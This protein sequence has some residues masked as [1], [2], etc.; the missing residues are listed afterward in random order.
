MAM[1]SKSFIRRWRGV[2]EILPE[3][4][5]HGIERRR[6]AGGQTGGI[7][8]QR[9]ML[10]PQDFEAAGIEQRIDVGEAEI[11]QVARH[12]DAVPSF[13]QKEKLPARGIGNLNDQAAIGAQQLMRGV[14]IARR[15]VEMLQH[16]KHGHGG[17]A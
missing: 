14:Q 13:A 8:A 7:I 2:S 6:Q 15:I 17:A 5:R 11:D 9:E 3:A 16:V 4:A 10:A 1:Y 12:V